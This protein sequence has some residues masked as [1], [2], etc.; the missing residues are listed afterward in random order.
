MATD[1]S[2]FLSPIYCNTDMIGMFHCSIEKR[3]FSSISNNVFGDKLV[4]N[5]WFTALTV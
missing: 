2:G 4:P 5:M 3:R 1:L